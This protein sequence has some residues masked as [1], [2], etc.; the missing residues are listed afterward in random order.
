MSDEEDGIRGEDWW[1]SVAVIDGARHLVFEGQ[2]PD[3]TPAFIPES[4]WGD[5]RAFI[6]EQMSREGE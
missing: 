4:R 3:Y 1:V 6:D 5:V 2:C